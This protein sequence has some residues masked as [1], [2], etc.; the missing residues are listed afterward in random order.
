VYAGTN[1]LGDIDLKDIG[2]V[3]EIKTKQQDIGVKTRAV[4]IRPKEGGKD[5]GASEFYEGS[6]KIMT[7]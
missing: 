4:K 2:A 5:S 7:K 6:V 3:Y 1:A